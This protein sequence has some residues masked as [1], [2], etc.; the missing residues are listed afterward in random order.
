MKTIILDHS[1]YLKSIASIE[2]EATLRFARQAESWWNRHFSWKRDGCHVLTND[3][4]E[5]LAYLFYKLDRYRE[6]LTIHNIFTPRAH[7]TQGYA[8]SMLETLFL[9][10]ADKN[11]GR[12]KMNCT[13]GALEFYAKLSLVYW[14]VDGAGNYF[15]DLP[16]PANGI[17]GI[18]EMIKSRSSRQLLN[19]NALSIYQKVSSNGENFEAMEEARFR[20]DKKRLG[21][22]YRHLELKKLLDESQ[23]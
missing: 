17:P 18:P 20:T 3:S 8:M 10:S 1:Q 13:S 11:V 4:G 21:K 15:C 16:L 19:G 14:G 5:H 23:E 12:F 9:Q 2:D 7:R 22:A 6:Y